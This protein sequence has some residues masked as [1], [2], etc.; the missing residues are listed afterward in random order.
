M[1]KKHKKPKLKEI[2]PDKVG[3]GHSFGKVGRSATFKSKKDYTRKTKKKQEL[4][5]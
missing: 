5:N 4:D 1:P 3:R 2:N